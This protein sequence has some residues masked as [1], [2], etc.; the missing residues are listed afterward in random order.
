MSHFLN[1]RR[2]TGAICLVLALAG[3]CWSELEAEGDY[4]PPRVIEILPA[5]PVLAIDGALEVRFS[6]SLFAENVNSDSVVIVERALVNETFI[7]DLDNP[8]LIDSRQ[9][10]V[11]PVQVS[12]T[13]GNTTI[14][15]SPLI[16]LTPSMNYALLISSDVR[17]EAGNPLVGADGLRAHFRYDFSTDTGAPT[18]VSNDVNQEGFTLVAPNRKRFQ[19][20]FDQPV[21]LSDLGAVAFETTTSNA[22]IPSI[23]SLRMDATQTHL[24]L[25]L[26]PDAQGCDIFSFGSQYQLVLT[27]GIVNE[28]GLSME[29]ERIDFETGTACE[30]NGV[31][32][33]KEPEVLAEESN[34]EL[35]IS[36]SRPVVAS[37]YYGDDA[38]NLACVGNTPCPV[39]GTNNVFADNAYQVVVQIENLLVWTNYSYRV[40]VED[41]FG[42][43]AQVSGTFLTEALPKIAINE[44]MANPS[45]SSESNGE[46]IEIYNHG[47]ETYD[48]AGYEIRLDGGADEGG[49]TCVL[50]ENA[51]EWIMQPGDYWVLTPSSFDASNY[52]GIDANKVVSVT[53]AW[54]TLVNSRSQPVVLFDNRGRKLSSFGGWF[55]ASEDGRSVERISAAAADLEDNFCFSRL[56]TGPSPTQENGVSSIGC[57][58]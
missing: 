33:L 28:A 20:Q 41:D 19:V 9:D 6:E 50:A 3:G 45:T 36:A 5:S 56:D 46:Y 23:E 4:D 47:V 7:S 29:S 54:C 24:T 18:M 48:L 57:D 15:V 51:S 22:K 43:V 21:V 34:A 53:G 2:V 1:H 49:K 31:M 58:E 16:Q 10:D 37:V 39:Q 27:T 12:L 30:R 38:S 14:S 17:D 52:S 55:V 11:V 13:Q 8:P 44:V 26:A 25:L 42:F 35:L 32:L 40:V